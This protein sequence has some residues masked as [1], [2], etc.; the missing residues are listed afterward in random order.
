MITPMTDMP[1]R[2]LSL[3]G[4]G[5]KGL[6]TAAV[7]ERIE[8]RNGP[9]IDHFDLISGTSVGG[10]IALALA[11]GKS[12]A[13]IREFFVKKGPSIF[14]QGWWFTRR[15]RNTRQKFWGS[16]YHPR[17]LERALKEILGAS[18][19]ADARA[20]V[21]IPTLDLVNREP[22]VFKT[23]HAHGLNRDS[24]R[25]MRDVA[26]ATSAAPTFFP[27][28][29][30]VEN[31]GK[32]FVD[33]GLWANN[34]TLVA[35]T[36]AVRYFVGDGKPYQRMAILSVGTATE[37]P[38]RTPARTTKLSALWH[39]KEIIATTLTAQQRSTEHFF[40]FLA[41]AAASRPDYVRIPEPK[42]SSA[43]AKCIGLDVCSTVARDIL[44]SVGETV[45][46][47][48]KNNPGVLAFFATPKKPPTFY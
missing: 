25:L 27:A 24:N 8:K 23:D 45:G 14:P 38:G 5:Y 33:G 2:I 31:P 3:D 43:Q 36:E 26:R 11:A 9:L 17:G 41:A 35:Y 12:A 19:M 4:G 10:L 34:P 47:T 30:L 21:C 1:F 28:A 7:L 6:Y 32:Q 44:L 46:D 15:F 18:K 48:W 42:L 37:D 29:V 40:G 20:L 39:G 16:K 13:E 22:F